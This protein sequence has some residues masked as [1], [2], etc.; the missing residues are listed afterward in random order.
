MGDVYQVAVE[1]AGHPGHSNAID[2]RLVGACDQQDPAITRLG[3]DL[4]GGRRRQ[5][6]SPSHRNH[7]AP[8]LGVEIASLLRCAQALPVRLGPAGI[9]RNKNREGMLSVVQLLQV[10]SVAQ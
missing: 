8:H 2:R 9:V 3:G 5:M 6:W 10:C 4:Q 1:P 7:I